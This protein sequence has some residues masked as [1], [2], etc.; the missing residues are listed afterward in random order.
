VTAGG[1]GGREGKQEMSDFWVIYTIRKEGSKDL[2]YIIGNAPNGQVGRL[3]EKIIDTLKPGEYIDLC[4]SFLTYKG[5][6]VE[7][8]GRKSRMTKNIKFVDLPGGRAEVRV[9]AEAEG[10]AMVRRKGSMPFI[11]RSSEL[12]D[13]YVDPVEETQVAIDNG[14]LDDIFEDL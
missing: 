14:L 13:D 12:L 2:R 6:P 7:I 8:M 1:G 3:D 4:T 11:V 10:Y 9:M 5:C